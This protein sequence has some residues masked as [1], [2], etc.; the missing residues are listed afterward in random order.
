MWAVQAHDF[1]EYRGGKHSCGVGFG[2]RMFGGLRQGV[3][4]TEGTLSGC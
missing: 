2:Q 1:V 4:S 3:N